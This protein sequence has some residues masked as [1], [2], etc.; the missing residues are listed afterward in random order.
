MNI[1]NPEFLTELIQIVMGYSIS[2]KILISEL[3][4]IDANIS[5]RLHRKII[6]KKYFVT[7]PNNQ[8]EYFNHI[9][10][11]YAYHLFKRDDILLEI[12]SL[13]VTHPEQY[14]KIKPKLDLSKR[15]RK[16]EY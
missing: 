13:A 6:P 14:E 15:R 11:C 2:N 7:K 9:I 3:E 12:D 10:K 16:N 5:K 1:K 4:L 8:I